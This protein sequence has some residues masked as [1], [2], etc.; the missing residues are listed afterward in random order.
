MKNVKLEEPQVVNIAK[1][2]RGRRTESLF[3]GR[4]P[5]LWPNGKALSAAKLADQKELTDLLPKDAEYFYTFFLNQDLIL[6]M[7]LRVMDKRRTL[8]LNKWIR[9][10]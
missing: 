6:K 2:Q 8:L 9:K 1:V 3:S 7:T 4:M 5:L 10:V